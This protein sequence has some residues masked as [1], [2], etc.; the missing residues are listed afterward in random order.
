MSITIRLS[1]IGKTNG[2]A[3]RVVVANTRDKRNG[4]SLDIL[5]S[6]NPSEDASKFNLDKEKFEAWKAKGALVS[7]AVTDLME[8]NYK[9]VTYRS[10]KI[11][12]ESEGSEKQ[13]EV[14][15]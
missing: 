14:Q 5:G 8:G 2:P 9:Y 11:I 7:K 15:E 10:K 13:A 1:R 6:Y 12:A 3:Y 4:R